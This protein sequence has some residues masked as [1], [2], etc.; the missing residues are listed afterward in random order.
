MTLLT[1]HHADDQVETLMMRINRGSGLAGLAG[2]RS[3]RVLADEEPYV[4]LL[5]PL[6]AFRRHELRQL[7]LDAGIPFADDPSNEDESYDRVRMRAQLA[8]T[9]W[10]DVAAVA[11]SAEHLGRA[12][13]TLDSIA[14]SMWRQNS[15][16]DG[17]GYLVPVAAWEEINGRLVKR[18]IEE[19]GGSVT[20]G[21]AIAFASKLVG[22]GARR[23]L[24]GVLVEHKGLH[25]RFSPEPPRRTG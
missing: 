16:K 12:A 4:F 1:A 3:Q 15:R 23:N 25:F 22:E 21:N 18:A 10:L 20:T 2:I 17:D 24:A 9:A 6:L 11:Q 7:V 8:E 13:S 19:L 5:R 14:K